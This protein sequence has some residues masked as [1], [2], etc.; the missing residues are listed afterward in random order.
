MVKS[1]NHLVWGIAAFAIGLALV[2]WQNQV[3][4]WAVFFLGLI[5]S[6]ISLSGIIT[7]FMNRH[8]GGRPAPISLPIGLFIMLL[9]GIVMLVRS[10]AWV[11]LS[12]I[13][14]GM[15]MVFVSVN[16]MIGLDNYRRKGIV[17]KKRYYIFPVLLLLAGAMSIWRPDFIADWIVIFVGC[18]IGA[19][20]VTEILDYFF[21]KQKIRDRINE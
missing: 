16:Q 4:S 3:L 15:V 6:V 1:Y 18:W 13:L 5:F 20:G 2:I 19:Y 10:Q 8:K 9:L 11:D 7:F 12:M 14:L 17:I 21:F